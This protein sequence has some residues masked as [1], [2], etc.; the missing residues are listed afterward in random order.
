MEEQIHNII[1]N[2]PL[3]T[4]ATVETIPT[5]PST[6]SATLYET[7]GEDQ[8]QSSSDMGA[9]PDNRSH[10]QP[11]WEVVM[12]ARLNPAAMPATCVSQLPDTSPSRQLSHDARKIDLISR[13]ALTVTDAEQL[14]TIYKERLD[15]YVYGILADHNSISSI[16]S[17]SPLLT[18]AVCAVAALHTNN[19]AYTRCYNEFVKEFASQSISRN[20]NLDDVRGLCIGAFWLGD[21]SWTLVGTGTCSNVHPST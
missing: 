18:A 7:H 1:N 5:V 10:T 4:V 12:D 20:H 2:G 11:A 13:G 3:T 15:H 8:N 14:F 16:R 17:G 21:M 9:S 6:S 19:T